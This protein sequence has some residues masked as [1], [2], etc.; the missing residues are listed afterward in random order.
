MGDASR[1]VGWSPL[2]GYLRVLGGV[3]VGVLVSLALLVVV[4]GGHDM[5]VDSIAQLTATAAQYPLGVPGPN[6]VVWPVLGQYGTPTYPP[7]PS[8]VVTVVHIPGLPTP[9]VA[10]GGTP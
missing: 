3:L 2:G 5:R 9:S 6:K 1:L 4:P 7:R 10:V 8:Y